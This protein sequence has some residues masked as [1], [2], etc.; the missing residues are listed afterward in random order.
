[1]YEASAA[2]VMDGFGAR[3]LTPYAI[4]LGMSNAFIGLLSSLPQLFGSLSQIPGSKALEKFPRKKITAA[5]ATTQAV[6][7]IPLILVGVLNLF[8][9]VPLILTSILVIFF[10]SLI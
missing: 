3:Y 5:A 9:S 2:S 1:I 10:Y 6:M 4:A 7:W 8:Y